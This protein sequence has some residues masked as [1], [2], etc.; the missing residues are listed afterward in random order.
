VLSWVGEVDEE[1]AAVRPKVSAGVEQRYLDA[2]V[3][4]ADRESGGRVAVREAVETRTVHVERRVSLEDEFE[5]DG[6]AG[7]E[8]TERYAVAAVPIMYQ[9]RF[10]C[11]VE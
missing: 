3:L 7:G 6:E 9:D 2:V 11:R 8:E 4:D 5:L 10:Y 1:T